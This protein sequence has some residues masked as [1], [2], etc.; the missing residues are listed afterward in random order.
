MT[1]K[2][3]YALDI[4]NSYA[5]IDGGHHKMWVIDQMIRALTG[6]PIVN[7]TAKD[8]NGVEYSYEA[9]GESEAYKEFVKQHEAGEDGPQTYC[10]DIGIAP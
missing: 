4:A 3:K 8:C 6:C 1:D 10:W 7:K 5:T 2:I 9:L